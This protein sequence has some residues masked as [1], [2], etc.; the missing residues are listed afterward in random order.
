MS[1][2]GDGGGGFLLPIP[3]SLSVLKVLYSDSSWLR[4]FEMGEVPAPKEALEITPIGPSHSLK[5][6]FKGGDNFNQHQR[7]INSIKGW[8]QQRTAGLACRKIWICS[9][10]RINLELVAPSKPAWDTG[11][12]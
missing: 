5:L 11:G 3:V 7:Q 4:G 1:G 12:L 9:Q 8:G 10:H 6:K 2:D